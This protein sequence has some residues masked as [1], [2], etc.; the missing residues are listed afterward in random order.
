[1]LMA[2]KQFPIREIQLDTIVPLLL[3]WSPGQTFDLDYYYSLLFYFSNGKM[4]YP[5]CYYSFLE[6]SSILY[7]IVTWLNEVAIEKL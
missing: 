7:R 6:V 5:N 4:A 1:M 2:V 3:N